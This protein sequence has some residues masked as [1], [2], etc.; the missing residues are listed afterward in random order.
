MKL[1]GP[2]VVNLLIATQSNMPPPH[3]LVPQ[4]FNQQALVTGQ[5]FRG[6]ILAIFWS[7]QTQIDFQGPQQASSGHILLLLVIISLRDSHAAHVPSVPQE[8]IPAAPRSPS[9][10]SK[11]HTAQLEVS[12]WSKHA[13]RALAISSL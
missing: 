2:Q 8:V 9:V 10:L 13:N 3:W 7:R 4:P 1:F 5:H 11:R 6:D 12:S